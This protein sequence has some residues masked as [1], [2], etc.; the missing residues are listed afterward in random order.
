VR[1]LN[2]ITVIMLSVSLALVGVLGVLIYNYTEI[3][4][5][6]DKLSSQIVQLQTWLNGNRSLLM[7]VSKQK[8]QLEVWL[9]GNLT[10][11]KSLS[12]E[13]NQ[14]QT[15]LN[16]NETLLK[17][18]QTWLQGNITKV[19]MLSKEKANLQSEIDSLNSEITALK[20]EK[21][22]LENQLASLQAQYNEYV[23]AYRT[24]SNQV[25]QRWNEANVKIFVTPEDPSIW[26]TVYSI[27]GG[28]SDMNDWDEAWNDE[29][30]LYKWVVNNI[31][32]K[33]DSPYPILPDAPSGNLEFYD[34]VWQFPNETL[35]LKQGDCEDQALLLCSMISCYVKM[36]YYVDCIMIVSSTSA[37]VAVQIPVEGNELAILDPAGNYYTQISG[38]LTSKEISNEINNWLNY[39][40]PEMGNDVYVYRVFSEDFDETFTSTNEYIAWMY[41]R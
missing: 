2:K 16:G 30:L 13:K 22:G 39:W 19:E 38:T 14:L 17:H 9:Q 34:E 12:S 24:L 25:N 27:T 1:S 10:R 21:T 36:Q 3:V 41:S 40:K 33:D 5:E 4:G 32:Y 8:D 31:E 7:D 18:T 26:S 37:H 15:W 28:W 35:T 6:K 29:E 23:N 20:T 11:I